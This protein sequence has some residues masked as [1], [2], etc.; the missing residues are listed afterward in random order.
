MRLM[1]RWVRPYE[2][3]QDGLYTL[4]YVVAGGMSVT[5]LIPLCGFAIGELPGAAAPTVVLFVL[6]WEVMLWRVVMVGVYVSDDGIK[7]RMVL[8]TRVIPWSHVTG[9][10]AG[11]AADYDAWQIWVSAR[12][13]ERDFE[14]PIWRRGS[15]A[16]HRNRI[17]LPP[18]EFA[19]VLA[20]L[21]SRH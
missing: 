9:A 15:R 21:D 20:T 19:A 10:W 2:R 7:I 6:M 3:D 8:Y 5:G 16:R 14:T 1:P 11:Q 12:D 18:E 4:S 17:L 13:P